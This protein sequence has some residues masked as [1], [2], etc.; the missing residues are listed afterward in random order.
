MQ[1]RNLE[2][3]TAKAGNKTER[4]KNTIKEI[5]KRRKKI[6]PKAMKQNSA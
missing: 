3:D 2:M 4:K 5:K 6:Q 1:K